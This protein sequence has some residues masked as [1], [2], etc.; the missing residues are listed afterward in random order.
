MKDG[1]AVR[2]FTGGGVN[3]FERQGMFGG[4]GWFV[5][6]G[7]L[8]LIASV[9]TLAGVGLRMRLRDYRETPMQRRVSL[10]QTTQAVLWI[11][12]AFTAGIWLSRSGDI[13]AIFF[14][15]PGGW[16]LTA[17]SCGLVA[18]VLSVANLVLLPLVWRG[19]RR[20][21]SWTLGRK[22]R[23]TATA[24]IF[25]AFSLVLALWGA[26]YPWAS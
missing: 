15:W 2:Y 19:G 26:I 10:V 8:A 16:L 18:S 23:F 20:V 1:R 5:N 25:A 21:D 24:L 3:A 17:S 4:G 22:L 11:L 9:A 12:A 14:D 7:L 13:A 6:L